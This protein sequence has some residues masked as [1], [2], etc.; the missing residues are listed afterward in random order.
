[1]ASGVR[2]GIDIGGVMCIDKSDM[3]RSAVQTWWLDAAQEVPHAMA[4]VKRLVEAYGPDNVFVISKARHRMQ[5]LLEIWLFST[6]DICGQTGILRGN[7]HFCTDRSG[8]NGKGVVADALRISHF[9]DDKLECLQSI[10]GDPA[11]NSREHVDT[12]GGKLILFSRS[13]MGDTRPIVPDGKPHVF[14][15]AANWK[16]V[17][18]ILPGTRMC[19]SYKLKRVTWGQEERQ[20]EED[21]GKEECEQEG[22]THWD[23][24][25]EYADM[26]IAQAQ[27]QWGVALLDFNGSSWGSEYLHL[28][29]GDQLFTSPASPIDDGW[30]HVWSNRL[31]E[32]GWVPPQYVRLRD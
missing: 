28:Q 15:S 21:D 12:R 22:A 17:L 13:G 5:R 6:M 7:I 8:P 27:G 29:A 9:V 4:G 32:Y 23:I 16:E 31:G 30:L 11:G 10:Y 14:V 19:H 1:M 25:E 3:P 20:G 2:V 18:N 24:E 26:R